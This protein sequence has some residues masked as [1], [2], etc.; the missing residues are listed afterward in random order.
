VGKSRKG[1]KHNILL[2]NGVSEACIKNRPC[3]TINKTEGEKQRMDDGIR[4]INEG[5]FKGTEAPSPAM[6]IFRQG[7]EKKSLP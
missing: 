7:G 3:E 4:I 1:K 5:D 2:G 6:G